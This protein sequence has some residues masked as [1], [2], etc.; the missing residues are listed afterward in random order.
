MH[1]QF[2][3]KIKPNMHYNVL[4]SIKNTSKGNTNNN[5][6]QKHDTTHIARL[7]ATQPNIYALYKTRN[8]N[9]VNR[10]T[11]SMPKKTKQVLK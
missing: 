1:Y 3:N 10:C 6:Y 2:T 9:T 7:E 11:T 8:K 4:N 5:Y